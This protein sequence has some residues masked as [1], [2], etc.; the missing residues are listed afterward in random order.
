M[1]STVDARTRNANAPRLVDLIALHDDA[2]RL[3]DGLAGRQG[4][5]EVLL[6]PGVRERQRGVGG[7]ELGDRQGVGVDPR[8]GGLVEVQRAEGAAGMV[9]LHADLSGDPGRDRLGDVAGPA[10]LVADVVDDQGSADPDSVETRA[11]TRVVLPLVEL[12][13]A[14]VGA[15]RGLGVPAAVGGGDADVAE[16]GHGPGCGFDDRP[17]RLFVAPRR[18]DGAG[19]LGKCGGDVTG[20]IGQGWTSQSVTRPPWGYS[21]ARPR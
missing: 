8:A 12:D 16:P 7:E 1:L 2:D 5:G 17:E 15:H 10:L 21:T 14:L 19:R 9:Q 18:V 6:G 3:S 20:S 4:P 11:L 13:H